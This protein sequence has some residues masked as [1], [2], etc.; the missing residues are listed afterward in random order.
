MMLFIF[1]ILISFIAALVGMVRYKKLTM[2]FKILSIY[3]VLV[4][5]QEIVNKF[6]I[7][8]HKN[9]YIIMHAGT[10]I[11]CVSLSIIY[12]YLFQKKTAKTISGILTS[13]LTVFILINAFVFE[14]FDSTF[15]SNALTADDVVFVIISL[16][17]FKQMLQYAVQVNIYKQGI[18]WFNSAV[19]FFS[20]TMFA[21]FVLV[22]YNASN[23]IKSE[24]LTFSWNGAE[25]LFNILLG[26]AI[27]V[28]IK[29]KGNS[30]YNATS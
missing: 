17:L 6:Y 8:L 24:I 11:K 30:M 23:N 15:P 18:F 20:G 4:F 2:P 27:L 19:L 9:N 10:L 7:I 12:Y 5:I 13:L 28:E 1:R 14:P 3:L 26:F 29:G 21:N 22:N 16:L 25:I